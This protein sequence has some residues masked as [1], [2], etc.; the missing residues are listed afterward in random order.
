MTGHFHF[1]YDESLTQRFPIRDYVV[2]SWN[3][4]DP[5]GTN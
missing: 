5:N 2:F 4:I 1:H 3:E